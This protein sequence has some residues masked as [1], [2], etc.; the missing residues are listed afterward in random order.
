MIIVPRAMQAE[1]RT[2]QKGSLR[3]EHIFDYIFLSEILE[4]EVEMVLEI[5]QQAALRIALSLSY[6]HLVIDYMARAASGAPIFPNYT[7][8][9]YLTLTDLCFNDHASTLTTS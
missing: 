3:R 8:A 2:F 7:K 9:I 1:V 6:K 5:V 4:L